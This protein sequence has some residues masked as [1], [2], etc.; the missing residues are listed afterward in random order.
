[1]IPCGLVLAYK[2]QLKTMLV[3]RG[4]YLGAQSKCAGIFQTNPD[5]RTDPMTL[6]LTAS[7]EIVLPTQYEDRL[8]LMYHLFNG[9][10]EKV[11]AYQMAFDLGQTLP[12]NFNQA[13]HNQREKDYREK[14]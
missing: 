12:Y 14:S 5:D 6:Q 8:Y 13:Q 3:P 4:E 9:N 2:G 10:N 7:G 11:S 1:M